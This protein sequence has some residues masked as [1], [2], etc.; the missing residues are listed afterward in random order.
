LK[1]EDE[2]DE[3]ERE[4]EERGGWRK[5]GNKLRPPPNPSISALS[6]VVLTL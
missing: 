3:K 4:K 2:E 5:K 1:E 6:L